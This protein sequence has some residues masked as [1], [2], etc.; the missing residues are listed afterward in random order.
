MFEALP[1]GGKNV[2]DIF[3]GGRYLDVTA[4]PCFLLDVSITE[5]PP[6]PPT[7]NPVLSKYHCQSII[8]IVLVA[9]L[10]HQSTLIVINP[11]DVQC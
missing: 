8:S 1:H 4:L 11:S 3:N 2:L 10:D 7:S 5:L 9:I 6:P